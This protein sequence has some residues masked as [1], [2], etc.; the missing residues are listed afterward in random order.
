MVSLYHLRESRDRG[1]FHI[2]SCGY[3]PAVMIVLLTVYGH[4]GELREE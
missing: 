2:N 4:D 1:M 3:L